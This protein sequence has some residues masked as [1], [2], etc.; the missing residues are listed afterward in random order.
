MRRLS[1]RFSNTTHPV[2]ERS[3]KCDELEALLDAG[4]EVPDEAVVARL[5]D[6]LTGSAWVRQ[7]TDKAD[8]AMKMIGINWLTRKAALRAPMQITWERSDL[9]V[10][11]SLS[12]GSFLSLPST[13]YIVGD[14]KP[15]TVAAL[16]RVSDAR[17]VSKNGEIIVQ[18][19]C[20]MS[21]AAHEAGEI[22]YETVARWKFSE[23]GNDLFYEELTRLTPGEIGKRAN[24][25]AMNAR[26]ASRTVCRK[27]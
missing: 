24:K 4:E 17:I 10:T 27:K 21:K 16:G 3:S 1:R 9:V 18:S 19:K 6:K 15:V 14:K 13:R 22:A 2:L 12:M 25:G 26:V 23:D 7:I 5:F 8:Q 20:Y 11:L